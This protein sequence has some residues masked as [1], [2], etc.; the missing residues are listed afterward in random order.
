MK[1]V[2][3]RHRWF[4]GSIHK[5]RTRNGLCCILGFLGE[6]CGVS[7]WELEEHYLPLDPNVLW[8]VW[9]RTSMAVNVTQINDDPTITDSL[10]EERLKNRLNT[11]GVELEFIN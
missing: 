9:A 1:L 6:Q 5:M 8:P 2:I 4:R 3:D 10:R 11:L 7:D